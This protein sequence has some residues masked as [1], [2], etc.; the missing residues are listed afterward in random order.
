M[1]DLKETRRYSRT[2]KE[3]VDRTVCRIRIV[4]A[5]R[6]DKDSLQNEGDDM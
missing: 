6:L 3:A 1:D 5:C 4:R 2:K